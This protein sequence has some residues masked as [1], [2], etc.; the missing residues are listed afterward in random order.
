MKIEYLYSDVTDLYGD[1]FNIEYLQRCI[2]EQVQIIKTGFDQRPYF[3]DNDDVDLIYMGA[4]ME[5]FQDNI[6]QQLAIYRNRL[7]QLIEKGTFFLLTGNSF[8]IFADKIDGKKAL[9][10]FQFEVERDFSHHHNSCFLGDFNGMKLVGF[11]SQFSNSLKN[12]HGF[13]KVEKGYGFKDDNTIEGVHYKNFYGT[14]LIGPLLILNPDFTEYLLKQMQVSYQ[15]VDYDDLKQ[16][17]EVRLK[18]FSSYEK[19]VEFKH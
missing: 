13:I 11:K 6:I 1:S 2:N 16:A 14:Y 8:E 9:G 3:V 4:T 10:L 19:L 17:Y 18:E 12:D 7:A 5:R 15:M